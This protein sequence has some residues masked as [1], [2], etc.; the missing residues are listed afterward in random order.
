MWN[1]FDSL[2]C[3]TWPPAELEVLWKIKINQIVNGGLN[4]VS[5]LRI[6]F[7]GRPVIF[8]AL[9][10][11]DDRHFG[12]DRYLDKNTETPYWMEIP[13]L[14]EDLGDIEFSPEMTERIEVAVAQA[15]RDIVEEVYGD[16]LLRKSLDDLFSW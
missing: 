4:I 2:D 10:Q 14:R 3:T 6:D 15:E 7:E 12:S 9:L 5:H 8:D 11:G 13:E 16:L 1:K